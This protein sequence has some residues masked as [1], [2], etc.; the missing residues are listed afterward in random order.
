MSIPKSIQSIVVCFQALLRQQIIQG[1]SIMGLIYRL[2]Y[3]K[4]AARYNFEQILQCRT[5]KE[6]Q[7]IL[8][9][10]F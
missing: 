2:G 6:V 8:I 5:K 4:K 9:A 1:G 3:L 7:I 10:Y